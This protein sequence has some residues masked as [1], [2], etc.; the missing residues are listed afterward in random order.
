MKL[1]DVYPLF[2]IEPVSAKGCRVTDVN[3]QE[4]L[5]FYGGHAVISIGHS[6][7]EYAQSLKNQIN[8][9]IFY[10][11][12]I[13]NNI[14]RRV[15]ERIIE[16]S[17]VNDSFRLFM[18][19]SGAEANENAIKLASMANPKNKFIVLEKG[20]HGRTAA[21]ISLTDGMK[22]KTA[23]NTDFEIIKLPIN[24]EVALENA[25]KAKDVCAV[26]VEPIQG[27]GGIYCCTEQ[28]LCALRSLTQK[29]DA[30]WIA[31]EIQCG[32]GRSGDF[33][34]FQIADVEPDIISMAKGMGNGFPV[35]GILINE[36]LMPIE[37]GMAGTT[38]GGNHLASVAV[39]SVLK[40]IEDEGLVENAKK[41]GNYIISRIKDVGGIK[42]IR[43]RG[44]M[45]GIEMEYPV[46]EMRKKL[47]YEEKVFTGSATNPNTIRLLPPLNI[48]ESDCDDFVKA[49][50]KQAA[51]F[52]HEIN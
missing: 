9:L 10:S 32:F 47:V 35:G 34:A 6:H 40:V 27:I 17:G 18:I 33:F 7:P 43:G 15:A 45:I 13:V 4:Y 8:K 23:F 1:L 38:F 49:F 42:E 44:L 39:L 5:D 11:N 21:A 22:H 12:S 25:L 37:H 28:Y 50:K 51:L 2:N 26:L 52:L 14:Q 36:N 20:F 41:M 19:N 31:D 48:T 30:L 3:G 46:G 16:V 29:Y 24:D